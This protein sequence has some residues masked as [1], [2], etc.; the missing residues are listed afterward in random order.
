MLTLQAGED[1]VV[2]T[3]KGYCKF[4]EAPALLGPH[5]WLVWCHIPDTRWE[6]GSYPS[7]EMQSMYSTPLADWAINSSFWPIT[8]T[9]TLGKSGPGSND[10][11]GV[12]HIP[13]SVRTGDLPSKFS[14][15]FKTL[16]RGGGY[17]TAEMQ[18]TSS[19]AP[20][21]WVW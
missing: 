17:S 10:N 13:Q 18:S 9:T 11:E 6:G 3:M 8:S 1:L 7:A 21:H 15:I 5:H 12:L 20:A 16:V 2:M 4:P 19:T 14:I